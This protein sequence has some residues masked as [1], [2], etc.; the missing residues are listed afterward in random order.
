MDTN[1]ASS[2]WEPRKTVV[3]RPPL[4]NPFSRIAL[5]MPGVGELWFMVYNSARAAANRV[6]LEYFLTGFEILEFNSD[7]AMEYGKVCSELRKTGRQIK[8]I[9]VQIAAIARVHNLII[10]TADKHFSYIPG[11]V[12]ENWLA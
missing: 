6:K 4:L 2:A 8:Q 3:R 7:A 1:H 12:V 10:L 11:I 5:C 9:D